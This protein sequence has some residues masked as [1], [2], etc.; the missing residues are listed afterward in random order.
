[1]KHEALALNNAAVKTIGGKEYVI[2]SVF[3]SDE[4]INATLL[5][6]AERKAVREM[7]LDISFA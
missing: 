7:G 1:M 4:D 3:A 2:K 5:K 6:L